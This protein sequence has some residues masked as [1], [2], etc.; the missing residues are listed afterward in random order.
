VFGNVLRGSTVGEVCEFETIRVNQGQA[1]S[2]K[3]L[4]DE[5]ELAFGDLPYERRIVSF[6]DILGWRENIAEAGRD[7]RRIARLASVPRRFSSIVTGG[8]DRVEGAHLTSFSDNV[9]ASV[10]FEERYLIWTLQSLASIQIGAALAGFW[11]RGA[12]TIGDLYHDKEI[13]FGPALNHAYFLESKVAKF[14]R[15]ILDPDAREFAA[16]QS[17]FINSDEHLRFIDPFNDGFIN[18]VQREVA[19][20]KETIARFNEMAGAQI[21]TDPVVIDGRLA[22]RLLLV[23]LEAEIVACTQDRPKE[24]LTWL[25]EHISKRLLN[26]TGGL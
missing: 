2:R 20:A 5:R 23:R 22:L 6:F 9:V 24:K 11:I 25:H 14:P 13:V 3:M 18:R 4:M 12:V 19:P 10:P 7:P 1:A 16:L 8:A 17:D 26:G 15:I 21:P